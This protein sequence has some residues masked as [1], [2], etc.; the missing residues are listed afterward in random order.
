MHFGPPP[1]SGKGQ[2]P[3]A[4]DDGDLT[5][6]VDRPRQELRQ[7]TTEEPERRDNLLTLH[8]WPSLNHEPKVVSPFK[9]IKPITPSTRSRRST[10][11]SV[12]ISRGFATDSHF[13]S[14]ITRKACVVAR[15]SHV[16]DGRALCVAVGSRN[17]YCGPQQPNV[18]ELFY[19]TGAVSIGSPFLQRRRNSHLACP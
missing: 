6:S 13:L 7:M 5:F 14:P 1:V 8:M 11:T 18:G 2:P 17:K 3:S 9:V 12:L 16:G 4:I 15:R 10:S 19:F